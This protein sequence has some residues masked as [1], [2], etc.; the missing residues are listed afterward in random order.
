MYTTPKD[1][2]AQWVDQGFWGDKTLCDHLALQVEARP[3]QLA[4]IDQTN[5]GEFCR[6]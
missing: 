4:V 6:R 2:I 3:H 1:R 5:R